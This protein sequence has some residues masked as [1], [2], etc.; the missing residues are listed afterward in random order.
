MLEGKVTKV[1]CNC[2]EAEAR[3]LQKKIAEEFSLFT[4]Y[5]DGEIVI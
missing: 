4:A 5:H 1:V 2:S 3:E